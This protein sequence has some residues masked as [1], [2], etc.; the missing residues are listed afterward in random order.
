MDVPRGDRRADRE[1]SGVA[2]ATEFGGG[3]G[4]F[5]GL[6]LLIE[7][8]AN[9]FRHQPAGLAMAVTAPEVPAGL[10]FRNALTFDMDR[11]AGIA[12]TENSLGMLAAFFTVPA[13][14]LILPTGEIFRSPHPSPSQESKGVENS[15]E[16]PCGSIYHDFSS[17]TLDVSPE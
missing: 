16:C 4:I 7:D 2:G 17:V 14:H 8:A 11:G 9:V 13:Y 1:L 12:F 10:F 5:R 15:E 3:A 6:A